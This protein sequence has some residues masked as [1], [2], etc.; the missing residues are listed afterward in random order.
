MLDMQRPINLDRH[1]RR[2]AY[3]QIDDEIV[4]ASVACEVPVN[5]VVVEDQQGM[6][7][8]RYDYERGG[9][10]PPRSGRER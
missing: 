4:E 7:P 9:C 8:R 5:G 6:L 3:E 2:H 10:R 1:Q